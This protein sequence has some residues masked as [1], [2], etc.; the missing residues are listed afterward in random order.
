MILKRYA[1][2]AAEIIDYP[3]DFTRWFKCRVGDSI[4]SFNISA[5]TGITVAGSAINGM[6]ITL[7]L[8]GGTVGITYL[9]TVQVNT[10][11]ALRKNA[12]FTVRIEEP[13]P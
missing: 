7:K 13:Q 6:V 3:V 11:N 4:A 5:D 12:V 10:A 1:K 9:V 2:Q 8:S